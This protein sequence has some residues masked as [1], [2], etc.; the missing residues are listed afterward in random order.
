M[1]EPSPQPARGE[2]RRPPASAPEPGHHGRAPPAGKA[3]AKLALGALGVVYGDIGTSPLYALK[4]CFNGPHGVPAS[5]ENV[6]GVLSLVV[7]SMTFVVTF[8]YLSFVMRADN[9][10]EGGILALLALVGKHETTRAGRRFLLV[11]GLFGAALLYGDGVI[12]PAISVL[13]AVEGIAVAAPA[14]AHWIVPVTVAILVLLFLFQRRGTATVGAVFGPIMLVWFACIAAIGV[15]GILLDPS[16]VRALQPGHAVAFF[17]RHRGHG[18]LVLGGVVLVITGAEALYADMGH[19]GKRPIRVAWLGLAMPALLLNYLGQGAML[20]RH[21]EAAESPFYLVVPQW[22]LY[23]MI[24]IATAAAIVA[25]QA[26]ISGAFSLTRQAV[27]LG[28]SPR[29]TIRHTSSTEIGQIYLPEVNAVV[30]AATVALVLGFQSSSRLAAAY[31]I[32]VTGTMII[33][34]LLFHRVA[35]DLWRWSRLQA[36]PLTFLF[37]AVDVSFFGANVVKIEEGGW[38]PIAAAGLVFALMS[39]WKRGREALSV[40]LR[41]AGLPLDLFLDDIRRRNPQRVPGTAVFMTG[42]TAN[43]PPVMLHHLKHNK[44]LHERVVLTSLLT[45]EVPF[46]PDGERVTVRDLG[47]G[48]FQVV[49]RYGFMETPDVPALLASLPRRPAAGPRLELR[50][51]DTTY[52]LGRETLLPT[53]PAKMRPWRKRL[54]IIMSRNAQT[55]TAFFGLPPN[56]VVEMGAQIQ[57]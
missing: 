54:F 27:Q 48:F 19:F 8:K 21:P 47:S 5:A 12:T 4:E 35:R 39:T 10:G 46:V 52:Y 26:L 20:L 44:I 18:F 15:H 41:D 30:G 53:G 23:P 38:F 14:L 24:A 37:L 43:A 55:A 50:P 11:L 51:M 1:S 42:N 13:G 17:L 56:R 2:S 36:W 29:V 49:A 6:L 25:S 3:L 31:G 34:T 22:G 33:T 16:I 32:A 28:Y 45:E 40:S 57:L 7:W 9:R